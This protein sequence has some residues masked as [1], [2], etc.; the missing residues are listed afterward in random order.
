[1]Y[2]RGPLAEENAP[3]LSPPLRAGRTLRVGG[4]PFV[5]PSAGESANVGIM[6]V[7]YMGIATG[8]AFARRGRTVVA[9]DVSG[10]VRAAL[11]RGRSPYHE[12]GLSELLRAELR[13]GRFRVVDDVIELA[14]EADCIFLCL[15]TPA[16]RNGSADL[17]PLRSAVRD[18][19]RALRTIRGYRLV[20][21]K[22]TVVPGTCREVIEPILRRWS[23]KGSRSLGVAVN[24]EF[25]SEGRMVQDALYPRRIV[26]G[27]STA[28]ERRLL[29][30]VHAGFPARLIALSPSSAELVKHASNAF[31]ALKVSYANELSRWTELLGGNVDDV[32][33]AVGADSRIGAAFLRAGPGF[34]GSCFDKDLRAFLHRGRELGLRLRTV[35]TTLEVNADQTVHAFDLISAS[36]G[37]LRGKTV[38]VLGLAFKAGTDDVRESRALPIIDRLIGAGARV[39]AHDP[40]ALENF[41]REWSRRPGKR[42]DRVTFWMSVSAALRGADLAVLQTDWPPYLRWSPRWSKTMRTPL[43]VDLRRAVSAPVRTRAG[44]RVVALG[45]GPT[46]PKSSRTD[47]NARARSAL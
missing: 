19:G 30:A 34:G 16:A 17:R 27:T 28:R 8:L 21:V 46:S 22:S 5:T 37:T 25:L 3:A 23:R 43:L 39:R 26:I 10:A 47:P 40:V 35:A 11:R 24:P 44:L 42:R 4:G 45:V 41:R 14:R 12:E 9:Y 20:V 38:A 1:M 7:G 36:A 33:A 2:A 13:R 32:A 15:P 18:L 6:G 29:R 31:L